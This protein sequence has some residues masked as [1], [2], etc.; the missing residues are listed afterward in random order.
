MSQAVVAFLQ[1][2]PMYLMGECTHIALL[3]SQ[4]DYSASRARLSLI[5]TEIVSLNGVYGASH[6]KLKFNL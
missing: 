6:R 5:D 4:N 3:V 1:I 2:S